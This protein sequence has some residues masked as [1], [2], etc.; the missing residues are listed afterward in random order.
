M[1][2]IILCADIKIEAHI[3]I[4]DYDAETD[5]QVI[6]EI[7]KDNWD[8]LCGGYVHGYREDFVDKLLDGVKNPR[9]IMY[10]DN[11]IVGFVK[12]FKKSENR[13]DIISLAVHKNYRN[14]G[15]GSIL[16]QYVFDQAKDLQIEY[17]TIETMLSNDGARRLYEE[18]FGFKPLYLK[19]YKNLEL[20][21]ESAPV[22]T[23]G[24]AVDPLLWSEAAQ[25]KIV[26]ADSA[27]AQA[28]GYRITE[29]L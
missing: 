12:Y 1:I 24:R 10:Y 27:L 21:R 19:I 25:E 11:V 14:K 18:K 4:R 16:L 5:R 9:K 28:H 2:F 13:F 29:L 15:F 20:D 26:I 23:L 22:L 3:M 6:K 7:I 8:M 17:V